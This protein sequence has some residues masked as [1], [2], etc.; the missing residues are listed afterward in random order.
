MLL[1]C[2]KRRWPIE[3]VPIRTIYGDESSH[4]SPLEHVAQFFRMV[5]RA[6]RAVRSRGS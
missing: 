3:W 2:L 5:A 4:I 1:E 6:R